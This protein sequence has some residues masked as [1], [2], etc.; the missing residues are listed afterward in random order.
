MY[1]LNPSNFVCSLNIFHVI[2]TFAKSAVKKTAYTFL[3]ESIC[4]VFL[5]IQPLLIC[6]N[7]V[8]I[9]FI[10]LIKLSIFIRNLH[11][12]L[13]FQINKLQFNM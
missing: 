8:V 10:L 3:S 1:N 12:F 9:L 4:S 11:K 13:G 7:I 2:R 5:G 6:G